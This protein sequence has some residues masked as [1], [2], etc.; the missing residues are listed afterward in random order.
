MKPPVALVGENEKKKAKTKK[1]NYL[2]RDNT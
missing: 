2:V 1:K